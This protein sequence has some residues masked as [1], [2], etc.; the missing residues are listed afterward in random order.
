M[1]F[2]HRGSHSSWMRAPIFCDLR[3]AP[4]T[5]ATLDRLGR[6]ALAA[7]RTGRELRLSNASRALVE[8]VRFAGLAEVL[9]LELQRQP[10]QRE[11]RLGV[12][13]ERELTDPPL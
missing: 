2:A 4:A 7:R 10:E 11:Q 5:L 9:R 13:E 8:L 3:G 6:L 1:I 12:E